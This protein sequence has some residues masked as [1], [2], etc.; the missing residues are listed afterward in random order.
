MSERDNMGLTPE[1]RRIQD[2]LRGLGEV[3]A[4]DAFRAKLREQFVSGELAAPSA[5]EAAP[6]VVT[7]PRRRRRGAWAVAALPAI[8][9]AVAFIFLGGRDVVW[10]LE[11]VRGT[12]LVSV[13]GQEV[14]AEERSAV[15]ELIG[16]GAR[17]AVP[18][19]VEV[20]VVLAGVLVM[21]VAGPA[22]FTIPDNPQQEPYLYQATVHA[23][24]FRVMTG[25]KF[26]GREVLVL[27]AEGRVEITGTT[28]AVFKDTDV[29]CVCVLEGTAMIGKDRDHLDAVPAGMRKVM[30]GDGREPMIIPIEPGHRD[31]LLEFE[32]NNKDTFT[33]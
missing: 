3:R 9:A 30:F 17:V 22:E 14:V 33:E 25:P 7:L 2:A 19:G 31:G 24:E 20:D 16:P 12:G 23:G 32:A 5:A 28:V 29:T 4:D 13:N 8:A 10:Q 15:A 18:A 11:D 1:Q 27:T 21:G 6:E 26:P